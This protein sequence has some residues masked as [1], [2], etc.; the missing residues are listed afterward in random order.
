MRVVNEIKGFYFSSFS[1]VPGESFFNIS[2]EGKAL[3][4]NK[5][6]LL[7]S[8]A[9]FHVYIFRVWNLLSCRCNGK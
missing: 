8:K 6:L 3:E 7:V 2:D 4:S 9:L 5:F 1:F